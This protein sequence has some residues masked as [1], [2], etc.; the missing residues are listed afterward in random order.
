MMEDENGSENRTGS[1]GDNEEEKK[2]QNVI[3]TNTDPDD[4]L[5]GYL[6]KSSIKMSGNDKD[7]DDFTQSIISG[8]GGGLKIGLSFFK[9]TIQRKKK[10]SY[11]AI[12]NG[13]LYWYSKE[14]SR[15]ASNQINIR[16][17]KIIEI[18]SKNPKE[19]Y[20]LI[21]KKCYSF[22]GL[23]EYEIKKWVNSLNYVKE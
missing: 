2:G 1:K 8:I 21:H 16:D 17:T 3:N 9:E 7:D 11:F 22:E 13:M 10:K 5:T 12:K 18:N 15:S 20:I 19:F 14:R 23:N 6:F 4:K